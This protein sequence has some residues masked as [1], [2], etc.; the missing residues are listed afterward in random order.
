MV[1]KICLDADGWDTG[2][3]KEEEEKEEEEEEEKEIL[4]WVLVT[5]KEI[6]PKAK[7]ILR[8]KAED[9]EIFAG[10]IAFAYVKSG[11][12]YWQPALPIRKEKNAFRV[13]EDS[14]IYSVY[15]NYDFEVNIQEVKKTIKVPKETP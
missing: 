1:K 12:K 6:K 15:T 8:E 14:Q 5:I 11:V 4:T 7:R 9:S 13:E 10:Y 3:E 2:E